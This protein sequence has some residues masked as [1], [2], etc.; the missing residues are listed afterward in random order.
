MTIEHKGLNFPY[1]LTEEPVCVKNPDLR[2]AKIGNF[3][4]SVQT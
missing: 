1:W 4:P 3:I 2:E